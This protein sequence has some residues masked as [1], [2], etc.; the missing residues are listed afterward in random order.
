L[1]IKIV[2]LNNEGYLSIKQSQ[3]GFFKREKGAGISSGLTFPDFE[4]IA[5]AN[6][7][8]FL[9]VSAVQDYDALK[10]ALNEAGPCFIN[11]KIDPNQAFAPKLG[12]FQKENGQIESHSL[13]K[14]SPLLADDIQKKYTKKVGL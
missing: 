4:L 2:V 5:Q 6:K 11:V 7:I 14:M 3:R 12:S 1:P 13:E 9:S 8:P 10:A